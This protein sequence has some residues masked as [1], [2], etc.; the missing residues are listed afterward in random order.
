M[1]TH[2]KKTVKHLL[3]QAHKLT[4]ILDRPYLMREIEC[5]YP[6]VFILGPPRSGTTLLYQLMTCSFNFAYI[7]NIANKFYRCPISA[8]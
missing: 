8:T 2:L 1:K 6:P 5:R 3:R 7:P 4:G